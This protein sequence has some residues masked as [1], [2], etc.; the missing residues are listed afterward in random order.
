MKAK[1]ILLAKNGIV[2]NIE[3]IFNYM[4]AFEEKD[5][6]RQLSIWDCEVK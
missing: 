6:N 2:H 3:Q 4:Y 1:G 5:N